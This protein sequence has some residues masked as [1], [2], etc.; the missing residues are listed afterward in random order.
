MR[1]RASA[2]R[3]LRQSS[4]WT[5]PS[6]PASAACVAA[7]TIAPGSVGLAYSSYYT[8]EPPTSG[9]GH[10]QTWRSRLK[11]GLKNDYLHSRYGADGDWVGLF[12]RG[13]GY[14][15]T[16]LLRDMAAPGR[17]VVTDTWRDAAAYRAFKQRHADAYAALDLECTALTEDERCL[18]EFE[19]A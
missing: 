14:V 5:R 13:E 15:R 3:T 4:R 6:A 8:H 18:G 9:P 12:R 2:T 1:G 7:A 10:A 17:Y 11:T 19:P 16:A